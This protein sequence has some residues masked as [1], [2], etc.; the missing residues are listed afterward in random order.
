MALTPDMLQAVAR[1]L[2]RVPFDA[3]DAGVV[4]GMLAS[5]LDGLARLDELD[6]AAVEPAVCMRPDAEPG[7]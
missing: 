5:Q 7:R 1:D 2:S 4:M 3:G 6:L